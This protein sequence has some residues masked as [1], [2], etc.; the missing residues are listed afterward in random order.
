[1]NWYYVI[2]DR[3]YGP[4]PD[5]Q[6][7]EL[8]RSGE[9]HDETL[10]WRKGFADWRPLH[11]ASADSDAND[12]QC[13]EC[14]KFF[15]QSEMVCL[16]RAW[17]C[18]QCKP[19]YLQR[20]AEG[21]APPLGVGELWRKDRLLIFHAETVFPDRCI[22]CNAP[23]DGYRLKCQLYWARTGR[24][25]LS[26]TRATIHVGLCK[27]HRAIRQW[28]V[29]G[30]IIAIVFGFALLAIGGGFFPGGVLIFFMVFGPAIGASSR[31]KAAKIED[32]VIW[33][34]G[35]GKPF[36]ADLPEWTGDRQ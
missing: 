33:L 28:T 11:A 17:V 22:R 4:V 14:R 30:F 35:V 26:H 1:M 3:R 23:A 15:L 5:A 25:V 9:I 31:L 27:R 6:F 10:V 20:I 13:A 24:I 21:I 19:V 29:I 34:R 18:A 32:G 12:R 36:L 16:N 8:R 7:K 2:N